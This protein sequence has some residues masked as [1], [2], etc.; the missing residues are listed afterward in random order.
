V[1]VESTVR[2]GADAGDAQPDDV[3][4]PVTEARRYAGLA[5]SLAGEGRYDE[6]VTAYR[7]A[8]SLEDGAAAAWALYRAAECLL[9]LGRPA[10][11]VAAC[12]AG[13]A[14]HAGLAELPWLAGVAS[15]RNGLPHQAAYWARRAIVLGQFEGCGNDDANPEHSFA[16]AR[17]EL[18][19]DVLRYAL[20]ATGDQ[21]GSDE[22]E[23]LF[24]AAKAARTS[25]IMSPCTTS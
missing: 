25:G 17:W 5:E 1:P 12:T 3:V 13:M 7:V 22:A 18:P 2:L 6:A 20:R 24:E 21:T 11:A 8:A 14:Q 10:D 9:V 23:R 4:T 16:P 15:W 19:Y